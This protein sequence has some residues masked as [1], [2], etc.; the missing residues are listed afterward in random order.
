LTWTTEEDCDD[1][2][3]ESEQPSSGDEPESLESSSWDP[4]SEE[5]MLCAPIIPGLIYFLMLLSFSPSDFF[6][7]D[8]DFRILPTGGE[9]KNEV[10]DLTALPMLLVFES[11]PTLMM[12]GSMWGIFYVDSWIFELFLLFLLSFFII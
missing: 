12:E 4:F 2:P 3:E 6:F 1:E 11:P 10:L 5:T 9:G 7:F 8:L